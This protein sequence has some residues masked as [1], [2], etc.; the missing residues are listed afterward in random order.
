M[1]RNDRGI[2]NT[3]EP[4]GIQAVSSRLR[5]RRNTEAPGENPPVPYREL[6]TINPQIEARFAVF[7]KLKP[8]TREKSVHCADS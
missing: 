7:S 1:P 6:R 4:R 2:Q 5:T 8:Q 3:T